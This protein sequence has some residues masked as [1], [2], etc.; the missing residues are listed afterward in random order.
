[1]NYARICNPRTVQFSKILPLRNV[2]VKIWR[3]AKPGTMSKLHFV[4]Q[5]FTNP[6]KCIINICMVATLSSCYI[7]F[8]HIPISSLQFKV[9]LKDKFCLKITMQMAGIQWRC[10]LTVL[11]Q[12]NSG[13]EVW[14]MDTKE[15]IQYRSRPSAIWCRSRKNLWYNS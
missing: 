4:C 3:R 5:Y 14:P 12:F 11:T 7:H 1:M 13:C 15:Q 8:K 9:S 2:F 10:I 6:N